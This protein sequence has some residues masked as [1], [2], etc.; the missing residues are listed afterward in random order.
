[1]YRTGDRG[2]WLA[3]GELA[4]CGRIDSQTKIR[5]VRIELDEVAV[6]LQRHPG[7]GSAVV[8]A[9]EDRPGDRYLAAY[10]LPA[11]PIVPSAADLRDFLAQIL[12]RTYLPA[13]FVTLD[14]MPLTRNA[15]VDYAAL[16]VP[17][18]IDAGSVEPRRMPQSS[19]ER[20]LAAIVEG[21]LGLGA[22]GADDDFFLLGGHSILATQV[23]IQ[24]R[25][26]FGVELT[27]R[28][29]FSTPTIA[30]F[31]AAIED[32]IIEQITRVPTGRVTTMIG[33]DAR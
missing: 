25:E 28:D 26:A 1:M 2:R 3:T 15:K 10:I 4:F 32:R 19:T 13:A 9:R 33:G 16:P 8:V 29:L 18:E 6:A 14:A 23:V 30:G 27:L 31:A 11:G 7:V 24:S 21:V 5:G 12:P 20:R 17:G 22:V